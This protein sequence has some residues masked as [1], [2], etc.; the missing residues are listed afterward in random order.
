MFQT[1]QGTRHARL[2]SPSASGGGGSKQSQLSTRVKFF[3]FFFFFLFFF[4]FLFKNSSQATQ[5]ASSSSSK[6]S[7]LPKLLNGSFFL[8]L[9]LSFSCFILIYFLVFEDEKGG[10]Q[11]SP[12]IDVGVCSLQ[13]RRPY[14]EDQFAV[15][16]IIIITITL[17]LSI[18]H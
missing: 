14:Q 10:N 3:F 6:T 5:S 13:G 8:L 7:K 12:V 1:P 9:F 16:I 18:N 17:N 11:E 2:A 15:I 4:D